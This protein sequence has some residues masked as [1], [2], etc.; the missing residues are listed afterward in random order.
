MTC[1]PVGI[2]TRRCDPR[3]DRLWEHLGAAGHPCI[4]ITLKDKLD[5]GGEFFRWEV[6][7][8]AAGA[9][10]GIN[11]FNQ[12]D[13]QLAKDLARKAMQEG[14]A[15]SGVFKGEW[16]EDREDGERGQEQCNG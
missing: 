11:P 8:A 1:R 14:G 10:L 4:R 15:D 16:E 6:A 12:P 13:V 7:V 3:I 5:L 9:V 2:V